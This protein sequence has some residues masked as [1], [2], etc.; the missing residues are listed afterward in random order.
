MVKIPVVALSEDEL[1]GAGIAPKRL[2][3][4]ASYSLPLFAQFWVM[5][6]SDRRWAWQMELAT[7]EGVAG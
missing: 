1:T 7:T 6:L 5:I 2:A 4:N 3:H